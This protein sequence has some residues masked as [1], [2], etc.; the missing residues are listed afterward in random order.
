MSGQEVSQREIME[1]MKQFAES[2]EKTGCFLHRRVKTI[3]ITDK[4]WSG[5]QIA[6]MKY[7]L[8]AKFGRSVEVYID[9]N[10]EDGR[11][12]LLIIDTSG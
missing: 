4:D 12:T 7:Q 1:E 2:C 8:D 6:F 3:D 10:P 11:K 9:T 5:T